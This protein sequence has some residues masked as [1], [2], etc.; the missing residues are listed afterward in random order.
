MCMVGINK[1]IKILLD[2]YYKTPKYINSDISPYRTLDGV[3]VAAIQ[4]IIKHN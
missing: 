3:H 4:V 1:V 2:M